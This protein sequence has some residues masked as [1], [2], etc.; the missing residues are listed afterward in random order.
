[1]NSFGKIFYLPVFGFEIMVRSKSL[2]EECFFELLQD[3]LLLAHTHLSIHFGIETFIALCT[4]VEYHY[5]L[6]TNHDLRERIKAR[7]D[8][9]KYFQWDEENVPSDIVPAAEVAFNI[10]NTIQQQMPAFINDLPVERKQ[11]EMFKVTA[12][13]LSYY[14]YKAQDQNVHPLAEIQVLNGVHM[15]SDA[16][17]ILLQL[18]KASSVLQ[19]IKWMSLL[20]LTA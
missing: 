12:K 13:V 4:R 11:I 20:L 8:I 14:A 17:H 10:A 7:M 16:L 18:F 1:M 15:G 2:F 3:L 19:Y 5:L 9:V 6:R